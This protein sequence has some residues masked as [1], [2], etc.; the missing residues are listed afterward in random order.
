MFTKTITPRFG[1]VEIRTY[2]LKIGDTS[3]TLVHEAWQSDKLKVR[4]TSV[5]VYYDFI[6][7]EAM[8]IPNGI[9]MKLT[10][11]TVPAE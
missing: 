10:E 11:H 2:V 4:G 3:V 6:K 9:K 8:P 1:D 5:L 7:K